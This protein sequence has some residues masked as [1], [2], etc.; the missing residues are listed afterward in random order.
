MNHEFLRPPIFMTIQYI[1][2]EKHRKFYI[3]ERAYYFTY[4]QS[5]DAFFLS[6]SVFLSF[7]TIL[8]RSNE[9]APYQL[10]KSIS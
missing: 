5:S 7:V 4:A 10:V 1:T 6:S 2:S 3:T 8:V 9:E